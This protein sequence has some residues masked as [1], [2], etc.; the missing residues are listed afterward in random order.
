MEI[1]FVV[2][3]KNGRRLTQGGKYGTIR[4]GN[5][6]RG[7][8][9]GFLGGGWEVVSIVGR[10]AILLLNVGAGWQETSQHS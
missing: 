7:Y 6:L 9:A 2:P 8:L 10:R 5:Q 3:E 1:V 4:L